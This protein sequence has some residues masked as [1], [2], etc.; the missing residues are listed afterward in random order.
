VCHGFFIVSNFS[1]FTFYLLPLGCAM[2]EALVIENLDVSYGAVKALKGVSLRVNEGEVVALLGANGA[3]KS[4]TLKAISGLVKA[5]S[6]SIRFLNHALTRL[7]PTAI[8]SLGLAHCPEGRRVFTGMT[9]LENL[10]LG[11]SQRHDNEVQTDVSKMFT[12]FPIL[13]E[14][15]KQVSGTLSG[16][17]QQMLALARALMSRPK[18]LLLDE[19]SLGLAP[20]IIKTIFATL[21]QLKE[22]KVTILLVEQNV[23]LALAFADRAYVLRTGQVRL[24]GNAKDLRDDERVT[25]A[26]LGG[27][28]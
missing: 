17:E 12:M 16:G 26:Y 7:T 9:V 18:M 25:E 20:L 4:T 19:P 3:G 1:P 13:A 21:E 22:Q 6:G 28:A 8:V 23:S 15:R 2:P 11:A 5:K 24:E 27:A 14:R 10:T